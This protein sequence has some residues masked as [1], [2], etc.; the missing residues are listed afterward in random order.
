MDFIVKEIKEEI[1]AY[2]EGDSGKFIPK[3]LKAVDTIQRLGLERFFREEIE[4]SLAYP[5]Q[6]PL[7]RLESR[8]I[9]EQLWPG[10]ER[11]HKYLELARLDLNSLQKLY[12]EEIQEVVSWLEDVGF[13]KIEFARHRVVKSYF[14]VAAG[15]YEPEYKTFRVEY[16]KFGTMAALLDDIYDLKSNCPEDLR[17]LTKAIHRKIFI[18]TLWLYS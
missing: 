13:M 14:T 4:F 6:Y 1:A 10:D 17:L 11:N 3:K 12:A 15:I 8:S 18:L 5:R 16:T 9:L 2:I 7:S